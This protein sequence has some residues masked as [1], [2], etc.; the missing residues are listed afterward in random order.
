MKNRRASNLIFAILLM[1]CPKCRK[2]NLFP[3]S[4]FNIARLLTINNNCPNCQQS[5]IPEPG[6]YFGAMYFSYAFQ[7][8]IFVSSLVAVSILVEKPTFYSYLIPILVLGIGLLPLILRYSRAL[9]LHLFGGIKF[10]KN[11]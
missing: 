10:D 4:L 6:F 9:M 5:F 2:G 7:V 11:A 1:R 8:A 3:Y